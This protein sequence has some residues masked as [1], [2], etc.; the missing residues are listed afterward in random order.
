MQGLIFRGL[1]SSDHAILADIRQIYCTRRREEAQQGSQP[2]AR[3]ILHRGGALRVYQLR[4]LEAFFGT[5]EKELRDVGELNIHDFWGSSLT[6]SNML[7]AKDNAKEARQ[8]IDAWRSEQKGAGA[9]SNGSSGA[10]KAQSGSKTAPAS[11]GGS[12][13]V[14]PNVAEARDW[15]REWRAR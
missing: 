15:I 13:D 7:Q 6:T 12:S 2:A 11:K 10:A 3:D 9:K 1:P 14:P 5:R 4:K 8:W